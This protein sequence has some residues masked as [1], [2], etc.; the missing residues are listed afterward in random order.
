MSITLHTFTDD[1]NNVTE[2]KFDPRDNSS[3][4]YN[5][6]KYISFTKTNPLDENDVTS[7]FHHFYIKSIENNTDYY[8]VVGGPYM[9]DMLIGSVTD[10]PSILRFEKKD[11]TPY[12]PS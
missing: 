12:D 9:L 1:I 6:T 4:I 10:V 3:V 11:G 2:F 5:G 7:G 8:L